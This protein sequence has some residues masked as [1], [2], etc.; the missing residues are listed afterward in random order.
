M[1]FE[2][3]DIGRKKQQKSQILR[4]KEKLGRV[5]WKVEW[6]HRSQMP[7]ASLG[8]EPNHEDYNDE[9][10][11]KRCN[12]VTHFFS[13]HHLEYSRINQKFSNLKNGELTGEK[14]KECLVSLP[15]NDANDYGKNDQTNKSQ[16]K[17]LF[18]C[19]VLRKKKTKSKTKSKQKFTTIENHI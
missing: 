6:V 19:F 17:F 14:L 18:A 13:L 12:D 10:D 3:C 11:Q 8:W 1:I 7:N 16:T 2:H 5:K 4:P 9:N 15:C